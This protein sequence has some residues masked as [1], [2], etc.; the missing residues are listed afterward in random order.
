MHEEPCWRS[1]D[2]TGITHRANCGGE[3]CC[4]DVGVFA[5]NDRGM[6]AQFHE[7]WCHVI[8]GKH[9]QLTTYCGRTSKRHQLDGVA[10]NQVLRDVGGH[11]IHK[12]QHAGW[13]PGLVEGTCDV[14]RSGW[15]FFGRLQDDGAP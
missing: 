4:L 2:L 10:W 8:G 1:A 12:I 5:D 9:G 6:P 7:Y 11:A 3:R 14:Q 15:C 13:K